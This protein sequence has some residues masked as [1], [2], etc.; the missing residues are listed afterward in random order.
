[1]N[2]C[3]RHNLKNGGKDKK[4]YKSNTT[5][6]Q[7]TLLQLGFT[8]MV[9]KFENQNKPEN[10]KQ[11]NSID[12]LLSIKIGYHLSLYKG[13]KARMKDWSKIWLKRVKD[14]TAC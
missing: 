12:R 11:H 5:K 1:M 14:Y 7:A 6:N 8:K 10:Q 9:I 4:K 3:E 2:I 13:K